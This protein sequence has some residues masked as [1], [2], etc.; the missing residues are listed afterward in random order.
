MN[1]VIISLSSSYR[2]H[3]DEKAGIVTSF[4]LLHEYYFFGKFIWKEKLNALLMIRREKNFSRIYWSI[5]TKKKKKRKK[6]YFT[7]ISDIRFYSDVIGSITIGWQWKNFT[8]TLIRTQWCSTRSTIIL[9]LSLCHLCFRIFYSGYWSFWMLGCLPFQSMYYDIGKNCFIRN[10]K[11]N[12][13][14]FQ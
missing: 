7:I 5:V 9:L 3:G 4:R 2:Y 13:M 12:S 14:N 11:L 6:I 10:Q 1:Y 8:I